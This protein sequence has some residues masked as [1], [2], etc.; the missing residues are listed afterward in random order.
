MALKDWK[1]NG[2]KLEW[3]YHG[4]NPRMNEIQYI[5]VDHFVPSKGWRFFVVARWNWDNYESYSKT[6]ATAVAEAKSYMRSH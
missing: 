3:H 4:N 1:K 5:Y 6:K 2:T